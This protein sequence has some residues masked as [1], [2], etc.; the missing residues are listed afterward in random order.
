MSLSTATTG[1]LAWKKNEMTPDLYLHHLTAEEIEELE[2]ALKYFR[3]ESSN[4]VLRS[5]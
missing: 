5:I 2:A 1:P 3:S 4:V